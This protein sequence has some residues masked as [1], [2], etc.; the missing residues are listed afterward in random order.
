MR[1]LNGSLEINPD[2]TALDI[3][4]AITASARQL[5]A[6]TALLS[7]EGFQAF[8]DMA[9]E[10]QQT[11]LGGLARHADELELLARA[12]RGSV[13]GCPTGRSSRKRML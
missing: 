1:S 8:A 6:T 4:D 7:G 5:G 3:V 11:L 10:V 9:D 12:L 13:T 2:A